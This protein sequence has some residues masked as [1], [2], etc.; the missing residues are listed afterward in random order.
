M[1]KVQENKGEISERGYAG[2]DKDLFRF[3]RSDNPARDRPLQRHTYMNL[4]N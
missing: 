2:A 1:Q 3:Y 4:Y